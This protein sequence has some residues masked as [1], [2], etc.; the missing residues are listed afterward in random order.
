MAKKVTANF[1]KKHY[2]T[3]TLP[4]G[5]E[6]TFHWDTESGNYDSIC[7][8]GQTTIMVSQIVKIVDVGENDPCSELYSEGFK[9][10]GY[11]LLGIAVLFLII[12]YFL[13]YGQVDYLF[14]V[15][16]EEATYAD[17]SPFPMAAIIFHVILMVGLIGIITFSF[18][19]VILNIAIIAPFI[20]YIV[21][22]IVVLITLA[23][24][25]GE[26]YWYN[27]L[28]GCIGGILIG[29]CIPALK[30]YNENYDKQN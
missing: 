13:P 9:K 17:L 6:H 4:N 25:Q 28:Y 11:L 24:T 23:E 26:G 19:K 20:F 15:L 8:D 10:Y 7:I 22:F 16:S 14:G 2:Y 1:I 30:I 29:F 21:E 27:F 18:H 3:I 12:R 5:E